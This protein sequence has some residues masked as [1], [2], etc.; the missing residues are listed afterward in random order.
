MVCTSNFLEQKRVF[1]PSPYV[2]LFKISIFQGSVERMIFPEFCVCSFSAFFF[3][4]QNFQD[5]L[6]GRDTFSSYRRSPDHT[7]MWEFSVLPSPYLTRVFLMVCVE[8]RKKLFQKS[9]FSHNCF[10]KK[11]FPSGQKIRIPPFQPILSPPPFLLPTTM[12]L[13]ALSI[14]A[15]SIPIHRALVGSILGK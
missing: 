11:F 14:L 13:Y 6:L 9:T 3:T 10:G 4:K 7:S 5:S 2:C 8:I 1:H 15:I 12:N